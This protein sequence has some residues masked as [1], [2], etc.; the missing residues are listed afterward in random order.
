M[1]FDPETVD[2]YELGWK[3]AALDRRLRWALAG[4]L[5]NYKDV[6]VPGSAGCVVNGVANFCG[7]TTNAGK[8][9]F[10]GIELET[11]ATLAEDLAAA[12]DR[13]NFAGSLGYL[14]AEYREFITNIGGPVD[15][16]DQR[17]VQNTPKWTLSGSVD[18]DTP[19][20]GGRLNLNSTV[21]YRRATQ[22]FE[23]R[24]PGLDQ[25]GFALW[26]ANLVWRAPGSRFTVGLH[27]K[28]LLDKQ[29]IVSGYNFLTQNPLTGDYILNVAGNPIPAGGLGQTGV[30][31]AFYG[32]PRQLWLSFGAR[33]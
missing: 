6:Q 15:V 9:R 22:Q 2:S 17:K 7:I 14:N 11:S 8:A 16:S 27:G 5:A 10:K 30:L 29:Y 13:L 21:S 4:F 23:I 31:T 33:F 32:N 20:F 1:D 19:A 12:G 18:Y 26:D 28:N 24:S 3:G 25:A